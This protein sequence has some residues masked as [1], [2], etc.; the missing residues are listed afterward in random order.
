VPAI[1]KALK[2][3]DK[4]VRLAAIEVTGKFGADAKTAAAALAQAVSD[5]ELR[6][7]A[8]VALGKI[9]A[10]AAK[11]AAGVIAN[12]LKGA[13]KEDRVLMLDTLAALK[14]TTAEMKAVHPK[15]MALVDETDDNLRDKVVDAFVKIGK[16]AVGGLTG[17]LS[18]TNS[19][20]RQE[21]A[22]ALGEIGPPA[23]DAVPA[24]QQR[25]FSD[26]EDK[27]VRAA[28]ARALISIQG[29]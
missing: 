17:S 10:P 1:E 16:P 9:G 6:K 20:H 21:A 13:P 29:R 28:C 19:L 2:D 12:A 14:P 7:G 27:R 4:D 18:S 22:R 26:T 8:L 23:K 24:L 11:D 15:M 5:A 25:A 3:S